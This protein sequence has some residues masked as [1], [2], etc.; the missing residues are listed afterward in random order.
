MK[1]LHILNSDY[2]SRATMGIR[3]YHIASRL[4]N[5]SVFCRGNLSS[6]VK[7][8]RYPFLGFRLL[9]RAIQFLR[10]KHIAFAKLKKIEK[11]AFE[12][13][14]KP[15]IKDADVIHFFYQSKKLIDYANGLNKK[16]IIEGFTNP[17]YIK[18]MENSGIQLDAKNYAV[19]LEEV[20]CYQHCHLLISPSKWV[21]HTFQ[22]DVNPNIIR[23]VYYGVDAFQKHPFD[24][25]KKIKF[26][27]AG[28]VKRTKGVIEL[29]KAF[30]IV[31]QVYKDKIE[32]HLYGRVYGEIKA[33]V[34]SLLADNIYM[35]GYE[36]DVNKIYSDKHV[37]VLA[38]Y[39]EGS[40]KTILEAM[41]FGLPVITT[42]NSGSPIV[43]PENGF[44][45]EIGDHIKLSDCMKQFIESHDLIETIG[46]N[47]L[48]K[49]RELSWDLYAKNV[50]AIYS[51]FND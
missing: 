32:L 41:S 22:S 2:G 25:S 33:E 39:F 29:L 38:S 13:F 51:E 11:F 12:F 35:H 3:S 47:N 4:E 7:N 45:V 14:C 15:Y 17:L 19:D 31:N 21:T 23:E 20:Y 28:G 37:Y 9:S 36:E 30:A 1:V 27:F 44:V 24:F 16:T 46:E 49:A 40:S 43:E 10:R 48:K 34:N 8:I 50:S 5:V 26:C 42:F 6:E 18:K